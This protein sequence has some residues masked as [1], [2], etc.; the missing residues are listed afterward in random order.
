MVLVELDT[1]LVKPCTDPAQ[2]FVGLLDV[3]ETFF[4]LQSEFR[5]PA[6]TFSRVLCVAVV[7]LVVVSK[8]G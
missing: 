5:Q 8:R 3:F 4:E 6:N 7:A 2:L 1:H